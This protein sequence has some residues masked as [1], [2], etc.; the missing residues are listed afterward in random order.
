[1]SDNESCFM[2][3]LQKLI[4]HYRESITY[5]ELIG[6][7]ELVKFDLCDEAT[8]LPMEEVEDD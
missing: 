4:A 1:M 2:V 7:L 5:G 8:C 3:D 6:C